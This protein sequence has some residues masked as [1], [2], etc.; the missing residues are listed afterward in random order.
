MGSEGSADEL[1]RGDP[2]VANIEFIG[3]EDFFEVAV[4]FDEAQGGGLEVVLGQLGFN[5]ERVELEVDLGGVVMAAAQQGAGLVAKDGGCVRRDGEELAGG[6]GGEGFGVAE[7]VHEE[8]IGAVGGVELATVGVAA[9]E[10]SPGGGV[11][12]SEA[13]GP[14][15]S[16]QNAPVGVGEEVAVVALL[17]GVIED[18]W[19][20]AEADLMRAVVVAGPLLIAAA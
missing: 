13:A 1:V 18:G 7:D 10:G 5:E 14:F 6:A 12:L 4:A 19:D 17:V 9:E 16:F 3:I 15:G 11:D 20:R 2:A 8:G